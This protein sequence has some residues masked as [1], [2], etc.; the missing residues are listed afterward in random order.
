MSVNI[1]AYSIFIIISSN[2]GIAILGFFISYHNKMFSKF[3][4]FLVENYIVI[5]EVHTDFQYFHAKDNSL[6]HL[7][8]SLNNQGFAPL[9]TQK[10]SFNFI[11]S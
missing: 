8:F 11:I 9:V 1:F 5:H 6:I 2:F 3:Y 10:Y 4:Y 7:S